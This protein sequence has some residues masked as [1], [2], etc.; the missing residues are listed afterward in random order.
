MMV[1]FSETDTDAAGAATFTDSSADFFNGEAAVG[2]N[3]TLIVQV[4]FTARVVGRVP[5]VLVSPNCAELVPP[6][7]MPLIVSGAVPVLI[8]LTG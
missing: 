6:N 4:A 2:V 3:V 7:V 8:T 1:P 5:Q